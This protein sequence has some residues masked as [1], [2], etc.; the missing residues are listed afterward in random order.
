M[1]KEMI[2]EILLILVAAATFISV[3]EVGHFIPAAMF[4]LD[5]E[6]VLGDP[7]ASGFLTLKM[8]VSF[9]NTNNPIEH[10][11]ILLGALVPPVILGSILSFSKNHYAKLF[12][13]VF[14][15]LGLL[16]FIPLPMQGVDA[17]ILYRTILELI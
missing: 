1:Y 6:F 7:S 11:F 4:G 16:T 12:A 5:P 9:Q 10:L 8:G 17:N 14:L 3:H 15:I 2:L 13:T